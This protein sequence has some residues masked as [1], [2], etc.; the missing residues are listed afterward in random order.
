[1]SS[2]YQH[3]ITSFFRNKKIGHFYKNEIINL[4]VDGGTTS[5]EKHRHSDIEMVNMITSRQGVY[6][7]NYQ[8]F[9]FEL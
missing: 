3:R 7:I 4:L 2:I 8:T 9:S 1:M 6:I 5:Q